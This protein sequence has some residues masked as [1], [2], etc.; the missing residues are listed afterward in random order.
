MS[1]GVECSFALPFAFSSQST[2]SIAYIFEMKYFWIFL[3]IRTFDKAVE[4]GRAVADPAVVEL[5]FIYLAV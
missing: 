5:E 4:G 2:L 3:D 1:Q